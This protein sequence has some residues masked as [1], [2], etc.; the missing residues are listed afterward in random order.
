MSVA[1]YTM[2]KKFIDAGRTNGM[3]E[4]LAALMGY[5]FLTVEEYEKLSELLKN[6]AS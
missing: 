6:K 2:Y 4:K 1:Y 3:Q 5:D